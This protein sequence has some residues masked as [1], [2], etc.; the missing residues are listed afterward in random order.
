MLDSKSINTSLQEVKISSKNEYVLISTFSDLTLLII[1]DA[2]WAS[3]NIAF[4]RPIA[5]CLKMLLHGDIICT[6][7]LRRPAALESYGSYG[8]KFFTIHQRMGP[9]Q[10]GNSC[11]QKLTSQS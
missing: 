2:W 7:E 1:L 10:R 8:F 4:K 11:W 5:W 9:A 6:A 3:R